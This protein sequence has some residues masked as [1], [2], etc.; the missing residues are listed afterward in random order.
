MGNAKTFPRQRIQIIPAERLARREGNRVNNPI[1]PVP[2]LG[3]AGEQRVDFRV[4]GDIA[5]QN[6]VGLKI[7]CEFDDAIFNRVAL[8]G[9]SQFR[10]L[11]LRRLRDAVGDG[12]VTQQ[13]RD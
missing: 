6:N 3:Q 9:E 7:R 1:Q 8:I 2:A 5:R 12:A 10:A 4:A 13:T 11:A